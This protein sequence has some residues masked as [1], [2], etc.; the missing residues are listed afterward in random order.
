MV[1][2]TYASPWDA[3]PTNVRWRERK[4]RV[5]CP[6]RGAGQ[7]ERA[8]VVIEDVGKPGQ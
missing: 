3:R 1:T 2:P 6:G 4:G 5:K 7:R 8:M